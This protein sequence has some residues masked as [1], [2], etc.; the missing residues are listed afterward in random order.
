MPTRGR[1]YETPDDAAMAALEVLRR[2]PNAEQQEYMALLMQNPSDGLF[3]RSPF[4]TTG[5]RDRVD[6]VPIQTLGRPRGVVHNHPT[7]NSFEQTR[8][9]EQFSATDVRV[10]QQLE[11][12]SFLEAY[13]PN[14]N[15]GLTRKINPDEVRTP[16]SRDT[17][18]K[19]EDFLAQFPIEEVIA[20]ILAR[21]PQMIQ[22]LDPELKARL[23][24]TDEEI[25]QFQGLLKGKK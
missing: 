7:Q 17:H 9:N 3:Y 14:Q 19:G 6:P 24:I 8:R 1:G 13:K 2:L 5:H 18:F 15:V 22:H 4:A 16:R 21:A 10:A 25:F 12:P 20:L 11:V 23:G